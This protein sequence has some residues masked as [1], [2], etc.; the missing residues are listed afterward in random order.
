M[1]SIKFV[2]WERYRAWWG[3]FQLNQQDPLLLERMRAEEARKQAE[4]LEVEESSLSGAE[5]RNAGRGKGGEEE[6]D[7]TEDGLESVEGESDDSIDPAV[8]EEFQ[9]L[10]VGKGPEAKN[11]DK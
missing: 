6:S 2:L 8:L 9:R 11:L 7:L 1:R 4:R 10:A 5:R 3:A